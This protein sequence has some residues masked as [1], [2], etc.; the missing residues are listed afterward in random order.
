MKKVIDNGLNDIEWTTLW[1]AVRYA[2]S[3]ST[4]ACES[5]PMQIIEY[6]YHRLTAAQKKSI[7]REFNLY[8]NDSC[9]EIKSIN[10]KK[11][12]AALDEN[13]HLKVIL[14]D[15]STHVCFRVNERLYPLD[16]YLKNPYLEVYVNP[17][18]I[19]NVSM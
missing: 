3:R 16:E 4:I 11:L 8:Q 17:N 1:M 19:K 12:V 7:I 14:K 18:T 9:A 2:I 15:L 5:L 13:S 6:Y 10:W